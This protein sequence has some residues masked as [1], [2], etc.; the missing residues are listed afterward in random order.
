MKENTN[1]RIGHLRVLICFT[2]MEA[3][4]IME[5]LLLGWNKSAVMLLLFGLVISWTLHFSGRLEPD[6][7]LWL[8]FILTMLAFFYYGTHET[9]IYDLAPTIIAFILLMSGTNN[10]L[11]PR[12]CTVTYFFTM[13]YALLFIAQDIE[14]NSLNV[15]RTGLHFGLVCIAD[16]LV[17]SQQQERARLQEAMDDKVAEL[18]ENNRKMENFLVNVSHELRTPINAIMGFASV[19]LDKEKNAEKRQDVLSIQKAGHR[20][21][22]QIEDILDYTEIDM[23]SMKINHD[24]YMISSVVNDV[25]IGEQTREHEHSPEII[26]D[27]DP[28][29]P[30]RLV[31]DARKIKKIIRHLIDNAVKFTAHGAVLVEISGRKK[32]YG[33]NLSI[34]VTDTG[35]GI[36]EENIK[37]LS[38]KF[39]Q[40]NGGRNRSAGGLGLGLSIVYGIV[41]AMGGFLRIESREG[42]GTCVS[43]SIP[44]R[45]SDESRSISVEKPD[46]LCIAC[47]LKPEKYFSTKV[48]RFYDNM[49]SHMAQG[50]NITMHRAGSEAELERVLSK[51]R[52]THLFIAKEEYTDRPS[53]Y[54]GLCDE[55]DV[56]VVTDDVDAF[57]KSSRVIP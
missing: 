48:F 41:S 54:E 56:I 5:S 7:C 16:W 35:V 19:I 25:V 51:Y 49:I 53:Y 44:Q 39:Y 29:I 8:Y 26:F 34:K 28:A 45:V 36:K 10:R 46:D 55:A 4:L 30:A 18:E 15:T 12:L 24:D 31:G 20:L 21:F 42:E 38:G 43:V 32:D 22:D 6:L 14:L 17:K 2:I 9:S 13:I 23:G 50:L 57:E 47:Y 40:Q 52:V 27:V 33:I 11:L 37:K 1:K 3:A